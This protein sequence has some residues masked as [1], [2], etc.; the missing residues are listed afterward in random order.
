MKP[1]LILSDIH[2]NSWNSFSTIENHLNSRLKIQLEEVERAAETLKKVNSN[3]I[4]LAGDLF[5]HRGSIHPTVFNPTIHLFDKLI[6]QGFEILAIPGNHDLSTLNSN[7]AANSAASL[8]KVGVKM[9]SNPEGQAFPEHNLVLVPWH[10]N[11]QELEVSCRKHANPDY[12][13]IIHAPLNDVFPNM[14]SHGLFADD[15]AN[16]GFRRVFVGHFHN[17]KNFN[18]KVF[19]IGALTHN[20]WSD[21]GSKAG[22]IIANDKTFKF[23]PTKAPLFVDITDENF[24]DAENLVKGN[25]VRCKIKI[26]KESDVERLKTHFKELGALNVLIQQIKEE[27]TTQR[28]SSLKL[29]TTGELINDY[30]KQKKYHN[31]TATLCQTI[32]GQI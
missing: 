32:L 26:A 19:S 1:F 24:D 21:V 10:E 25:Y 7:E 18:D 27:T 29:K 9:V 22:F 31:E 12:D 28:G 3:L 6:K 4:V 8:S 5:H 20:S 2:F 23:I 13:L 17:H 15:V 30:V 11:L 14:P 16:W